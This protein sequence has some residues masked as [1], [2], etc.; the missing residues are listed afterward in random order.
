MEINAQTRLTDILEKYP[1]LPGELAKL[2]GR[3][4][5]LKTPVGKMM[6]KPA[7]ITDAVQK[8]GLQEDVLI[9]ELKKLIEAHG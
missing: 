4:K 5:I 7:T 9:A 1:W 2:D 6:I 8:T 3:L